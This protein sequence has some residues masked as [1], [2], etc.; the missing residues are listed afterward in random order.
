MVSGV[1]WMHYRRMTNQP[2]VL[3]RSDSAYVAMSAA[4]RGPWPTALAAGAVVGAADLAMHLL[5]A[6]FTIAA[7]LSAAFIVFFLIGG[8][9]ALFRKGRDRSHAWALAHPWSYAAIPAAA[10]A[11]T[12]FGARL[13][14]SM[15]GFFGSAFSAIGDGLA[16][17]FI[18]GIVGY[19]AR[20]VRS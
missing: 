18:L 1:W 12:V 17:M 11:V 7:P 4:A 14:L 15:E 5:T 10:T 19:V 9:G 16:V 8:G 3:S 13:L 20:A 6:S 2:D